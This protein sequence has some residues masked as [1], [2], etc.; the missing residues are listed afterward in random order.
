MRNT[1]IKT[2]VATEPVSATEA[3]LFCKVSGTGDDTLFAEL[4]KSARETIEQMT[5][6]SLAEKTIYTEWD[7]LPRNGIV[8]L[9]FGPV[10][11]I[12]AVTLKYED[13]TEADTMLVLN[14]DYYATKSPWDE[15]R[16]SYVSSWA[17]TRARVEYV[18]GYGATGCPALPY[19]LKTAIYK[20][21]LAQYYFREGIA[22]GD[23]INALRRE[24]RELARPYRRNYGFLI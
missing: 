5:G 12:T 22:G 6:V 7:K 4:I 21:I 16:I 18:V 24:S 14:D 20:E 3:K 23:V 2:D 1:W 15:L 10:K 11:S 19:M 13:S 9:P 8:E 17:R